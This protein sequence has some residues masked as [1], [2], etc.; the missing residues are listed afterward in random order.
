MVQYRTERNLVICVFRRTS[1]AG[2]KSSLS[3]LK[4]AKEFIIATSVARW[5]SDIVPEH[6]AV[7]KSFVSD[8]TVAVLGEGAAV[9]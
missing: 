9:S 7:E 4:H 8:F 6:A 3:R 1:V 5:N 2:L